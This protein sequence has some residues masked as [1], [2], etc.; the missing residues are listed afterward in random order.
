MKNEIIKYVGI[1]LLII[2]ACVL[3]TRTLTKSETVADYASKHVEV[4]IE[5]IPTAEVEKEKVPFEPFVEAQIT[6]VVP[7]EDA[8]EIIAEDENGP[9]ADSFYIEEISEELKERMRGKSYADGIDE[10]LVNF[11]MLRHIVLSIMKMVVKLMMKFR[12]RLTNISL[13]WKRLQERSLVTSRIHY[14]FL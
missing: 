13:R 14:L 3:L 7:L 2:G 6:E 9:E 10:S 11:D 1:I 8:D 4:E 5:A 12:L